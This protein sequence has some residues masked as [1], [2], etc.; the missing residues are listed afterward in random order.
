MADPDASLEAIRTPEV[1]D[2]IKAKTG[3]FYTW[4]TITLAIDELVQQGRV[5]GDERRGFIAY[6]F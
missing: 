1:A 4:A 2:L 5:L 6:D 3:N